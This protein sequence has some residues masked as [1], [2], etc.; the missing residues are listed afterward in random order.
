[1]PW[2]VKKSGKNT[3]SASADRATDLPSEGMLADYKVNMSTGSK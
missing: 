1:V 2:G 3:V